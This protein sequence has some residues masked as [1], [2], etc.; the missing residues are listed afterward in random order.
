M[1]CEIKR[2]CKIVVV[3]LMAMFAFVGIFVPPLNVKSVKNNKK[4]EEMKREQ[5]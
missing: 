1:N 5:Q 4:I 2:I 3:V